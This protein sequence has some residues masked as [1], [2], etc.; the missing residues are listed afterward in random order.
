MMSKSTLIKT[1]TLNKDRIQKDQELKDVMANLLSAGFEKDNDEP[2][3]TL[4]SSCLKIGTTDKTVRPS[5]QDIMKLI[6]TC[7]E[8]LIA[9]GESGAPSSSRNQN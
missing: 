2:Y 7:G 4:S 9:N 5:N 3:S 1:W 6:S 8:C